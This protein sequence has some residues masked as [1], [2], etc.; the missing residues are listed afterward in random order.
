M[1]DAPNQ[2]R[3]H[4][5]EISRREFVLARVLHNDP[6]R[7]KD[8]NP[9]VFEATAPSGATSDAPLVMRY[10]KSMEDVAAADSPSHSVSTAVPTPLAPSESVVPKSVTPS[11]VT[12]PRGRP[13]SLNGLKLCR[14]SMLV[15]ATLSMIRSN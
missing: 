4:G 6:N 5:G 2:K 3:N 8:S 13:P 15:S 11:N 12:V 10:P 9:T 7:H 1:T 14:I